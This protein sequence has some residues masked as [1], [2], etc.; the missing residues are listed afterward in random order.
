MY[1][2]DVMDKVTYLKVINNIRDQLS[3]LELIDFDLQ[4]SEQQKNPGI[5]FGLSLLFGFFGFDRFY[6]NQFFL[7]FLKLF[8]LG[9][10]GI[11]TIVDWFIICSSTRIQN[12]RI[13]QE[14]SFIQTILE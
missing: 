14:I 8:T 6:L 5:A 9:G 2:W 1:L 12:I 13:A 11:W 7:G 3:D 10:L 4:F